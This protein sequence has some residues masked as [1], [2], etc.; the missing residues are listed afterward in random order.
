LYEHIW[1][2]SISL[3]KALVSKPTSMNHIH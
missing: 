2:C 1:V 3:L